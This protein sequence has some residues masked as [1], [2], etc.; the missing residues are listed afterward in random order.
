MRIIA[1][2]TLLGFVRTRVERK[3]QKAVQAHLKAWYSEAMHARWRNSAELKEQYRSASILSAE[4][5]VFNI[6]G[7]AYR[8][9]VAID[10]QYQVLM[11][12]WLGTHQEYDRIDAKEV[13][14]DKSRYT[15]SS[16]SDGGRPRESSGAD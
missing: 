3:Q 12:K 11:I 1:Q 5:V 13:E 6:K 7:N 10:Y 15:G 4:R 2:A 8:L 16:D 9:I 14:Y